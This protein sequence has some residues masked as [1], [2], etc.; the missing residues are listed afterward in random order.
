MGQFG[1]K[2]FS[3]R[4]RPH[5]H[6]PGSILFVTY[7]LAGSIPQATVRQYRAKKEWFDHQLKRAQE[8]DFNDQAPEVS[9]WLERVEKFKRDWFLKFEDILHKA[10]VGTELQLRSQKACDNWMGKHTGWTLT[11]LCRIMSMLF[12][13]HSSRDQ[14]GGGQRRGWGSRFCY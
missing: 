10:K 5:I 1:Y 2:E 6:P 14:S 3:E 13:S 9:A 4:H 7:R 11:Q 12:S 8:K